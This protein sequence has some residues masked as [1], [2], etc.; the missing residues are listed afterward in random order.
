MMNRTLLTTKGHLRPYLSAAIPKVT[1]PTDLNMSTSVIPHVISALVLPKVLARLET[2][3]ET[4]K[5][6]KASHVQAMNP[7]R[8]K[9]HCWPL[10]RARSLNGFAMCSIGGLRVDTLVAA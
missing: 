4:V 9:S 8:K 5:K 7:Q 3:S 6:S 10:S 1:A 2:V